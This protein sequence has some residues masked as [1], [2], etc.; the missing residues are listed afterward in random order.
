M[1][2]NEL[3]PAERAKYD[4]ILR[5]NGA[6]A[7]AQWFAAK[8][9]NRE[10]ARHGGSSRNRVNEA[11]NR[12]SL[13]VPDCAA[14]FGRLLADPFVAEHAACLPIYPTPSSLKL[15][16]FMKG[17]AVCGSGTVAGVTFCP[18]RAVANDTV[19]LAYTSAAYAGSTTPD[20]AAG[21]GKVLVTSNSPFA[22]TEF[23]A[24][25]TKLQY[26][27]VAAG[28]RIKYIG[29]ALNAGGTL[30]AYSHP[31]HK[32]MESASETDIL[33]HDGATTLDAVHGKWHELTWAPI[34][35][36]YRSGASG[37]GQPSMTVYFGSS[38]TNNVIYFEAIAHYEVIGSGARG[39]T[40]S[41]PAPRQAMAVIDAAVS[42]PT[43]V[44]SGQRKNSIV[45][46][47]ESTAEMTV[48]GAKAASGIATAMVTFNNIRK[49][50]T[51]GAAVAAIM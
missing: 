13:G 47:L 30:L 33:S 28:L 37:A 50:V 38:A 3:S 40:P 32:S 14:N 49:Y 18:E 5:D 15:T 23:G 25:D 29:T 10:T 36:D 19:S 24:T 4:R 43:A 9:A 22:D 48:A 26:R 42:A 46:A 7:A 41:H 45:A 34:D 31:E 1:K 8:N 12:F 35:A 51:A 20:L 27:V 11:T 2:L 39:K 44:S 16:T 17:V 6:K 21:T